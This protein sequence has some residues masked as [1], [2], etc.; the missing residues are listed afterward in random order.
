MTV[1]PLCFCRFNEQIEELQVMGA[2][3][4]TIAAL[5]KIRDTL[6]GLLRYITQRCAPMPRSASL[7]QPRAAALLYRSTNDRKVI[8]RWAGH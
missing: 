8:A 7:S 2:P 5:E 6:Q 1:G 3:G 4:W